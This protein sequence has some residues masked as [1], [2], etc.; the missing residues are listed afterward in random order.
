MAWGEPVTLK[1]GSG[2]AND[3]S[4][5]CNLGRKG[6]LALHLMAL[7]WDSGPSGEEDQEEW[8]EAASQR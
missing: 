1:S 4:A 2:F 8:R 6:D 3:L 5:V 7:T